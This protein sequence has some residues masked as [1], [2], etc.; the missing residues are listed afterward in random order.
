MVLFN[1]MGT[2]TE[3]VEFGVGPDP[4]ALAVGAELPPGKWHTVVALQPGSV[5]LELKEGPFN[6]DAAKEFASWAPEEGSPEA[7][8]FYSALRRMVDECAGRGL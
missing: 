8:R 1:D 6:E 4:M 3:V 7:A 2:P 5:L